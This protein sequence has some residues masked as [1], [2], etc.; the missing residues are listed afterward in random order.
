M[1]SEREKRT[2]AVGTSSP[3]FELRR[4]SSEGTLSDETLR[5]S[6]LRGR[7]VALIFGSYT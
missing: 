5:L 6:G 7:P 3:D 4:L 2:P 1:M